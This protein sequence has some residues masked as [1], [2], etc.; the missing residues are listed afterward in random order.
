MNARKTPGIAALGALGLLSL[1]A[2]SAKDA[3]TPGTSPAPATHQVPR[4]AEGNVVIALCDGETTL[5]VKGVKDPAQID[6][7]QAQAISDQLMAE[8]YR[9]NPQANWDPVPPRVAL[10]QPPTPPPAAKADVKKQGESAASDAAGVA[11]QKGDQEQAG[12]TYGAFSARDEALWKASAEQMVKEGHRVF[13]DSK[14]LGST[15]AISCDMCHPDGANTHPET[16]P[17]YQVQLGRVALLRDM[18]NWCIENPVRGKA[19]A[20]D[21][22]RMKAM[23][24][25]IFAQRKGVKLEYGKH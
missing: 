15:V 10:A 3:S 9:K 25:Y 1:G 8:W 17:K 19:L 24:A 2:A 16:Y 13:H 21:D 12:H 18:V 23:E 22:P 20:E 5:E 4:S 7:K 6:K 14:E 11:K